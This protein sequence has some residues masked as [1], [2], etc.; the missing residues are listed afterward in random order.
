M[1]SFSVAD[2]PPISTWH[3]ALQTIV[4]CLEAL[5]TI[6]TERCN[7]LIENIEVFLT[8]VN[9]DKAE[10]FLGDFEALAE[11]ALYK[12][13]G[14]RVIPLNRGLNYLI[15]AAKKK[16]L[17]SQLELIRLAERNELPSPSDMDRG[18]HTLREVREGIQSEY[19]E[20]GYNKTYILATCE[21]SKLR[22]DKFNQEQLDYWWKEA[23]KNGSADGQY[24]MCEGLIDSEDPEKFA[25]GVKWLM[26]A[27]HQDE[28]NCHAQ[29]ELAK[30]MDLNRIDPG[31]AEE[32]W[33]LF[34]AAAKADIPE[35]MLV[36][37]RYLEHGI[38]VECDANL[39][40]EW[41]LKAAES[42]KGWDRDN[43]YSEGYL[44]A[45]LLTDNYRHLQKAAEAGQV[46]AMLILAPRSL[47]SGCDD[48][49]SN[50]FKDG[51]EYFDKAAHK[52]CMEAILAL[53]Q[54][55]DEGWRDFYRPNWW[56]V[57]GED[58][59]SVCDDRALDYYE[60]AKELGWEY[61]MENIKRIEKRIIDRRKPE[62][63][64]C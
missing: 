44:R 21:K 52:G 2:T 29:Y 14:R 40:A 23:A 41:Y 54:I 43:P 45:G 19:T 39:A 8:G 50:S 22:W 31:W 38:G 46:E 58:W 12:T 28:P 15:N 64:D 20:Y 37:G 62:Q 11:L 35:A 63:D 10:L 7:A 47:D 36:A 33:A 42:Y 6:P 18:R 61:A 17:R 16:H 55:Y 1:S 53:A 48:Y 3:P 57:Y 13:N 24:R 60:K 51:L 34:E 59:E 4:R 49:N 26:L 5:K 56:A 30:L 25:E 32:R 27:A 9:D